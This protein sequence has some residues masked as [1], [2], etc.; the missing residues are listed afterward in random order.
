MAEVNP[1]E[2]GAQPPLRPWMPQPQIMPQGE[3]APGEGGSHFELSPEAMQMM[4]APQLQPQ[5]QP[6]VQ[7]LPPLQPP[8]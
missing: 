8:V 2:F 1:F 7:P 5:P 3:G 6:Q 4:W